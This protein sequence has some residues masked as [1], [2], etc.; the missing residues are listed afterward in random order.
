MVG[1]GDGSPVRKGFVFRAV[2]MV[3]AA[4]GGLINVIS[5]GFQYSEKFI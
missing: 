4:E 3:S 2:V 1:R 5:V